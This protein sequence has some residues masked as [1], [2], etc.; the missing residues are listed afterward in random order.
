MK[1]HGREACKSSESRIPMCSVCVRNK[2]FKDCYVPKGVTM[3]KI[4]KMSLFEKLALILLLVL[5]LQATYTCY[6]IN[7]LDGIM[8]V[9]FAPAGIKE[10]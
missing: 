7:R 2:V 5:A 3:D 6:Q 4:R 1:C 8:D 10:P 9:I